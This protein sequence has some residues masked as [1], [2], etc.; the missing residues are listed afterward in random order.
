VKKPA[1]KW[2]IQINTRKNLWAGW[3]LN[4]GG[5]ETLGFLPTQ[6]PLVFLRRVFGVETRRD[7]EASIENDK[8]ESAALSNLSFNITEIKNSVNIRQIHENPC[9]NAPGP[10]SYDIYYIILKTSILEEPC[11]NHL[12]PS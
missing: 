7:D 4:L 10:G 9:S 1:H 11:P 5:K 12:N 3:I 2:I 6:N 8:I